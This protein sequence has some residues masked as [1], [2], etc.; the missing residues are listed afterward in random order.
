[1]KLRNVLILL[2]LAV[3]LTACGT[4][5]LT[6]RADI[7]VNF[8]PPA[9]GFE[10]DDQGQIIV[11]SH[12]LSF[13]SRAGAIGATVNGYRI[14]YYDTAGNPINGTDSTLYGTGALGTDVPPG[15]TCTAQ[16][17]DPTYRCSNADAGVSY[18]PGPIVAVSNVITLDSS[19][20]Q[21]ML[22]DDQVGDWAEVF[23]EI[24]DDLNR[25]SEIGPYEVA[26]VVPVGSGN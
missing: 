26:L 15:I 22:A 12:V 20:V 16:Q 5:Y 19:V 24:T 2:G 17:T 4:W 9:L 23:F 18:K 10:V 1:M 13:Q 25:T 11:A 21:I 6:P 7:A 14:V 8:N 3:I